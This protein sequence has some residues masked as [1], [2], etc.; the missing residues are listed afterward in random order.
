MSLDDFIVKIEFD[1]DGEVSSTSYWDQEGCG[2]ERRIPSNYLVSDMVAYHL[3][4]YRESHLRT[5][6]V[7]CKVTAQVGNT[8][9]RCASTEEGHRSHNF[10][11]SKE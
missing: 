3:K 10:Q 11:F 8:I 4:H 7:S 6:P 9:L 1:N 2:H 5:P